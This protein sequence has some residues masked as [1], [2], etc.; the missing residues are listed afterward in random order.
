MKE[1]IIYDTTLRDGEQAPGFSMNVDEKI[2]FAYQLLKLGVNVIEA[3][4]PAASIGDFH[5]VKRISE[6]AG[7]TTVSALCRVKREDID[8]TVE[9]LA[10]AEKPRVHLIVPGSDIQIEHQMHVT[11]AAIPSAITE[12]VQYAK[13]F[14][15]E[16]QLSIMDAT[17]TDK[18]YVAKLI[19]EGVKAGADILNLSDTVGYGEPFE[20]FELVKY[21]KQKVKGLSNKLL[22]VHFHN[23]LGL[24]VANTLAA[25]R[26][27]ID[28]VECTV[29]GI[30][31]RAGNASLEEVIMAM[32]V[33]DDLYKVKTSIN[34]R[35]IMRSSMLLCDITGKSPAV[36]KAIVGANAF[37][38]GAGI[39]QDGIIK[40]PK[41]FEL[42]DPAVIGGTG[43]TI[44]ISKH[45]GRHGVM[46]K[47][48]QLGYDIDEKQSEVLIREI[49]NICDTKK[50]ISEEEFET[51]IQQYT[52]P[53]LTKP[54]YQPYLHL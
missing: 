32:Q 8:R 3:G 11:K 42:F 15:V 16:V 51:L 20:T 13:S 12:A 35:E 29:N 45:S 14:N 27:G 34:T 41:T 38:H 43:G 17:R 33:R 24:A 31:E 5:A 19:E 21:I 26:A 40:N 1:L 47:A 28:Q 23:D 44:F 9:A 25:V 6:I 39:H 46:A 50:F 7:S 54:S 10:P 18:S 36:N 37:S 4:F 52:G 2:I 53:L 30:G 48:K 22:S 49:K